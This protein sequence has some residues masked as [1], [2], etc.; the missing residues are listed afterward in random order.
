MTSSPLH[1][2]FYSSFWKSV[3]IRHFG[4]SSSAPDNIREIYPWLCA[5]MWTELLRTAGVL[6][7][8]WRL[9]EKV[10]IA[11]Y[12]PGGISITDIP[13]HKT[14][15][16]PH[17]AQPIISHPVDGGGGGGIVSLL[18]L[19]SSVF[20]WMDATINLYFTFSAG[21]CYRPLTG[22]NDDPY[23]SHSHTE[24]NWALSAFFAR[25]WING[26]GTRE[27]AAQGREDL[28]RV[29]LLSSFF[30]VFA[31]HSH[32]QQQLSEMNKVLLWSQWGGCRSD[33]SQRI[34][35]SS[36]CWTTLRRRFSIIIPSGNIPF[37]VPSHLN[38]N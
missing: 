6:I 1:N 28:R 3:N 7:Y 20:G 10:M 13:I 12:F 36:A 29:P 31:S 14:Q 34:H 37:G 33:T 24:T 11:R 2:Q 32:Q 18:K 23:A 8:F 25:D 22:D 26:R 5:K 35:F 19:S 15:S 38:T 17:T 16:P 27:V 9:S 21:T 4:S 30:G